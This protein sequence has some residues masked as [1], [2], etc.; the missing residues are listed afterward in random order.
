MLHYPL[1][2][3]TCLMAYAAAANQGRPLTE[4]GWTFLFSQ[5]KR[6]QKKKIKKNRYLLSS[7]VTRATVR[8]EFYAAGCLVNRFAYICT[9]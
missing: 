5:C 3:V 8:Q 9:T 2:L 4:E 7:T 6:G 1:T